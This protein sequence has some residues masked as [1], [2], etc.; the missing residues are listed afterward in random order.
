MHPIFL[1]IPKSKFCTFTG[2]VDKAGPWIRGHASVAGFPS[3]VGKTQRET[4]SCRIWILP[5]SASK[6]IWKIPANSHTVPVFHRWPGEWTLRTILLVL[7]RMSRY[8]NILDTMHHQTKWWPDFTKYKTHKM[9]KC[10]YKFHHIWMPV[11]L[12]ILDNW[13]PS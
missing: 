1:L 10:H 8:T 5:N 7:I 6:Q 12:F 13:F 9:L 2:Y 4:Y 11:V 3:P